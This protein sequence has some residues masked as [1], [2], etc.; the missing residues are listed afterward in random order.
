MRTFFFVA[1]LIV[2]IMAPSHIAEAEID[3][4]TEIA[5]ILMDKQVSPEAFF[6]NVSIHSDITTRGM[7]PVDFFAFLDQWGE[8]IQLF[9]TWSDQKKETL[10]ERF[11]AEKLE[12]S[13]EVVLAD[14]A[15]AVA[16][17][18]SLKQYEKYQGKLIA[19]IQNMKYDGDFESA[20]H[21]LLDMSRRHV[22]LYHNFA[23]VVTPDP[24]QSM[25]MGTIMNS[26]HRID[27][28]TSHWFNSLTEF[29]QK[30][31]LE[32]TMEY[33]FS[34][35]KGKKQ[36]SEYFSIFSSLE[37]VLEMNSLLTRLNISEQRLTVLIPDL[38]ERYQRVFQNFA[39]D[40]SNISETVS[41]QVKFESWLR[42]VNTD[43]VGMSKVLQQ[44]EYEKIAFFSK[45]DY[46]TLR[47]I[48]AYRWAETFHASSNF[49]LEEIF[50]Y[51]VSIE[52]VLREKY[53]IDA[54]LS[55]YP[56]TLL[57]VSLEKV[58]DERRQGLLANLSQE[59]KNV[60]IKS[61]SWLRLWYSMED[62][63]L[64]LSE[65]VREEIDDTLQKIYDCFATTRCDRA[66]QVIGN[67]LDMRLFL[68]RNEQSVNVS[69]QSS[70]LLSDVQ[71]A[72]IENV[73]RSL[74][75]NRD[76]VVRK[77][78]ESE[79][80]LLDEIFS[81][82]MLE[83]WASLLREQERKDVLEKKN[84]TQTVSDLFQSKS[85]IADLVRDSEADLKKAIRRRDESFYDFIVEVEAV[86]NESVSDDPREEML[87]KDIEK[88]F[89]HVPFTVDTVLLQQR[90]DQILGLDIS[91]DALQKEFLQ[92]LL[93]KIQMTLVNEEGYTALES[94][95]EGFIQSLPEEI[96]QKI[97]AT[98]D[99]KPVEGIGE[100]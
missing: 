54:L 25:N 5:Q 71:Q 23:P 92:S 85:V 38:G 88:G 37:R 16:L 76:P 77:W 48:G 36:K 32:S 10:Y 75:D 4:S 42:L 28:S 68:K 87:R 19:I 24:R 89:S 11:S 15:D 62:E 14:T 91:F 44:L 9:L 83:P 12:E 96:Q 100:Q 58:W 70:S 74:E 29:D 27:E 49:P 69:N 81:T 97:D 94:Q 34:I 47:I 7:T 39:E 52:D 56:E 1:V 31:L 65:K 64:P 26:F 50:S 2:S 18:K 79:F 46:H 72:W 43:W 40:V 21:R 82:E 13:L 99:E 35:E 57:N 63:K 86:V 33:W 22:W 51:S 20:R 59:E 90:L 73:I 93:K 45:I 30:Q 66:R 98:S 6:G 53:F 3:F 17:E 8:S 61:L 80:L 60:Y 78:Y 41:L 67:S 55:L 84:F 95:F